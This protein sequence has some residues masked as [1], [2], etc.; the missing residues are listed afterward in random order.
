MDVMDAE[1]KRSV[2]LGAILGALAGV[3]VAVAWR[4][5]RRQQRMMGSEPIRVGQVVPLASSVFAVI[6]QVL[7]LFL[8]PGR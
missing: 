2:L 1:E 8:S 4:R 6:R 7:E 3:G 5:W